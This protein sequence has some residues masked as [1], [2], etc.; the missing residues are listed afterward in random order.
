MIAAKAD[1]GN[2]LS[3]MPHLATLFDASGEIAQLVVAELRPI[4]EAEVR[5]T[6]S[7]ARQGFLSVG[8]ENTHKK[9]DLVLSF[10]VEATHCRKLGK[11]SKHVLLRCK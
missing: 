5:Y 9:A 11:W 2:D 7:D 4:S 10:N 8:T 1:C 3:R 6:A